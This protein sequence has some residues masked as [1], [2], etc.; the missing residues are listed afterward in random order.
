MSDTI[1]ITILARVFS[2]LNCGQIHVK[3]VNLWAKIVSN[4]AN[5]NIFAKN[6]VGKKQAILA[7]VPV[8][9]QLSFLPT[10][11]SAKC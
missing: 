7:K 2:V 11:N 1:A 9:V 10:V 4:K 6:W 3:I 8:T 5:I